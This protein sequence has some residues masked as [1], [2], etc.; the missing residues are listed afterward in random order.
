M[1]DKPGDAPLDSDANQDSST[2]GITRRDL[3]YLGGLTAGALAVPTVLKNIN[4]VSG[5]T[6]PRD[7]YDADVLV[8]GSGFAGVFAAVEA[9]QMGQRVVLVD[10]GTV[11]WSGMT[12]WASDSRPFDPELYNRKEWLDNLSTAT[13]WLYNR[14]WIPF[15]VVCYLKTRSSL[16]NA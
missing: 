3:L 10:K 7:R 8:V 14:P 4:P 16:S 5:S 15:S 1:T 2:G 6:A 12:P 11:G 13:E 9:A